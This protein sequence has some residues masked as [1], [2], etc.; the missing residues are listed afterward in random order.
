MDSITLKHDMDRF[1]A[2]ERVFS[3]WAASA[4]RNNVTQWL[5][6]PAGKRYAQHGGYVIAERGIGYAR[7]SFEDGR[8]DRTIYSPAPLA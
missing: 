4:H 7:L 5:D 1:G 8:P 2:L 6:S 3:R